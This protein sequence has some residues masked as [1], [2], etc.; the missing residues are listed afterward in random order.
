MAS[1]PCYSLCF[2]F[3]FSTLFL[4]LDGA[5]YRDVT[6]AVSAKRAKK[7]SHFHFYF[8][9]VTSGRN[10][11]AKIIAPPSAGLY[12]F[13]TTFMFDDALTE[14]PHRRSKIVGRAQ[15]MYAVTAQQEL[16]LLV[17]ANFAFTDGNYNGSSI[18]VVGRNP[19]ANDVR[20]MPVVGGSGVFRFAQGYALAHSFSFDRKTGNA[21]VEYNVSKM[22]SLPCHSLCFLFVFSTLFLTLEGAFYRDVTGALP[23]RRVKK[24]SHFHF[25]FHDVTTGRNATAKIVAP[26]SAG[27]FDFGATSMFDDALTESPDRRSKLVGRAQGMYAVTAQQELDLLFIANFAFTEGK[28]NGSSIAVVGRNPVADDVREMAVVGG[29]GLFR[30][31]QGY[32]LA[33]TVA[34]DRTTTDNTNVSVDLPS[35]QAIPTAM[36]RDIILKLLLLRGTKSFFSWTS[37]S[38]SALS[39]QKISTEN[40]IF[41]SSPAEG[42]D[43]RG[44]RHPILKLLCAFSARRR[45]DTKHFNGG[46][47]RR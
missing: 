30:L 40:S 21:V 20:E 26:P 29:S 9:D 31:A 44:D 47:G 4:T 35:Q 34:A 1:L 10:A 37:S 7:T 33:H 18:A 38:S 17:V 8:H 5:F 2:L 24:T 36:A 39:L 22:A 41:S 3:V 46:N 16:D 28:Y 13:G 6:G 15:G 14:T 43:R 27:L 12:D 25:Y 42:F 32:A 45:A 11:S 19:V 23:A